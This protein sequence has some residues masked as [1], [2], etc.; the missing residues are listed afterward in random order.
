MEARSL[1]ALAN[2]GAD[3][4]GTELML[5]E[6]LARQPTHPGAHHYRIH[7]WDNN[8]PEQAL[9]SCRRYT[10]LV[11]GIGHA[12]H[13]PGNIYSIVGMW[14]EAAISMDAATRVEALHEESLISFNNW[15]YGHNL[16]IWATSGAA[17]HA[18]RGDLLCP[19]AH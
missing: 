14:H 3:R 7:N 11:P 19:A 1:L 13:M 17:R 9:E 12:Q 15:N 2:M 16:I 8:E 10:E 18:A 4:Y 6:I 5:R